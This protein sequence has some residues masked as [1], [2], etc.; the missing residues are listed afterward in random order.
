MQFSTRAEVSDIE[1]EM[2]H[3][4]SAAR[5]GRDGWNKLACPSRGRGGKEVPSARS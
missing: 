2:G 4:G 1:M 5:F 3:C